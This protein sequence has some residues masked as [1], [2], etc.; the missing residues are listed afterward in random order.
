MSHFSVKLATLT[1]DQLKISMDINNNILPSPM[2]TPPTGQATPPPT[3]TTLGAKSRAPLLISHMLKSKKSPGSNPEK[4]VKSKKKPAGQKAW[5]I[6][7]TWALPILW[8]SRAGSI[9]G[10]MMGWNYGKNDTLSCLNIAC[11]TTK[12]LTMTKLLEP[13]SCLPTESALFQKTTAF[14]ASLHSKP[15]IKICELITLPPTPELIWCSGWMPWAWPQS[16]K[17]NEGEL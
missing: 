10:A 3:S 2:A 1:P 6:T 7:I 11:P 5:S 8:P 13:F 17:V 9:K 12:I 15:S 4:A 14:L 16:Y